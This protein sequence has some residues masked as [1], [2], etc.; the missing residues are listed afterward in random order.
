MKIK[1]LCSSMG[2]EKTLMTGSWVK[3]VLI[4]PP[5]KSEVPKT[6]KSNKVS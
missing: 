2:K 4:K 6:K 5:N 3:E 1:E